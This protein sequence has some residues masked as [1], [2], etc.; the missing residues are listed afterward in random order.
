M[1]RTSGTTRAE[2]LLPVLK[3]TAMPTWT[4]PSSI[5]GGSA[6]KTSRAA[7]ASASGAEADSLSS[8]AAPFTTGLLFVA[9]V[10]SAGA[11]SFA[12]GIFNLS[13]LSAV[14]FGLLPSTKLR[15]IN[16]SIRHLLD[17]RLAVAQ[18][19]SVNQPAVSLILPSPTI[20]VMV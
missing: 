5:E 13:F 16:E 11:G 8:V 12:P 14:V 6:A 1:P 20:E 15:L 4:L 19:F 18:L 10:A 9:S 7:G 17:R 3:P 2:G